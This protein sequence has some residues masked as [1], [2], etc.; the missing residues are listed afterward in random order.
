MA[1]G[2]TVVRKPSRTLASSNSNRS[3]RFSGSPPVNTIK[4][5][6]N[7]RI[8]SSRRRP[9]S[10]VNSNVF[11]FLIAHA[12]QCNTGQIAGLRQLPDDK[13]WCVI[14][15][16]HGILRLANFK[17]PVGWHRLSDLS[18]QLQHLLESTVLRCCAE[19]TAKDDQADPRDTT[20]Q[21]FQPPNVRN[22]SCDHLPQRYQISMQH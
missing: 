13:K 6:P 9:S 17:L 20:A 3:D 15:I 4:G 16:F 10:L 11:R 12:R 21:S 1:L 8:S 5:S 14:E 7:D 18:H 22:R 19:V 2:V